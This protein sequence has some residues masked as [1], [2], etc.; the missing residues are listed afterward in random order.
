MNK[1]KHRN[2]VQVIIA[3][4]VVV[5]AFVVLVCFGIIDVGHIVNLSD[6]FQY[7]LT[8]VSSVI[9]GF[10]FTSLSILLSSVDQ[11]RISRLYKG[12]YLDNLLRAA[13][14]GVTASIVT[15]C[16]SL[17][18]VMT[19]TSPNFSKMLVWI[20]M[21]SLITEVVFFCWCLKQFRFVILRAK[22]KDD[23]PELKA[24]NVLKT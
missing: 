14:I 4:C 10:L 24:S 23:V 12:H 20:E 8:S 21:A 16:T 13:V 5:G 7:N 15:V 18:I 9:G 17:L 1:T 2:V 19:S 6:S 22:K 3:F 11:P